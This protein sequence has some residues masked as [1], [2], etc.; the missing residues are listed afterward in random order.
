MRVK[1]RILDIYSGSGGVVSLK[2]LK[3]LSHALA[4]GALE[5]R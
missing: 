1:R 3:F 2:M 4:E 5:S